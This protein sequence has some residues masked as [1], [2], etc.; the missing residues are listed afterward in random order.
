MREITHTATFRP[1][2]PMNRILEDFECPACRHRDPGDV[3]PSITLDRL[4]IFCDCCA[5]FVTILLDQ[6]Q[7][8]IVLRHGTRSG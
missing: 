3:F 7:V 4:R 5:S 6:E 1:G 2:D 8:D